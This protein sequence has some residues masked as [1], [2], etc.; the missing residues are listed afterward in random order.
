MFALLPIKGNRD[1]NWSYSWIPVLGPIIGSILA[2][3]LFNIVQ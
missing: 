3:L 2:V 1:A